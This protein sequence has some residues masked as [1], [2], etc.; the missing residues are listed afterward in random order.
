MFHRGL[1]R[2]LVLASVVILGASCRPS[3]TDSTRAA[4]T[5]LGPWSPGTSLR[6]TF[7]SFPPGGDAT[8]ALR[9]LRSNT[10]AWVERWRL[11]DGAEQ[12]IDLSYFIL[13]QDAFGIAFLGHLLERAQ[14]GV[15]I[16]LLLD[17]QGTKM[18]WTPVG[19][20]VLDE[21][22]ATGNAEVRTYRP[23]HRRVLEAFLTLTPSAAV[24]SDH[25]KIIVVDGR[26]S[27]T[28]GRNIGAEYFAERAAKP[29]AFSDADL[30]IDSVVASRVLTRAFDAEFTS[31]RAVD[32]WG[33]V[34]NVASRE[35][36]LL[37]AYRAMDAWL[38]GT[39]IESDDPPIAR[40]QDE[41]APYAALRGRLRRGTRPAALEAEARIL[42][43]QTRFDA[44][45]DPITQGLARLVQAATQSILI[46]SPYLVL[47]AD[48]VALLSAAGTRGVETT[49]LTNSPVSSDNALSQAF[50][51][52]QW[53]ELLARVPKLRLF[54]RGE[55]STLH[56]KSTVFD[57]Q[58]ATVG[59]YNLDPTSQRMNSEVIVVVWSERFAR[60]VARGPRRLIARGEP[61]VYE[62]RIRRDAAGT[63]VRGDDGRPVVE[64]GP[65]NHS[66]PSQWKTLTAFW[67]MLR[68]ADDL[69]GVSPIL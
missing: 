7:E 6:G 17:A 30:A 9:L 28:G 47:S 64:F 60:E 59:T 67:T 40:W 3:Q 55:P 57:G 16:R 36:E 43:S 12:T 5:P 39:P 29:D 18:S 61:A 1:I 34:A 20:D 15:R 26:K 42:D 25:D 49:I 38:R 56:G 13:H 63:A 69:P 58:L 10:D 19:N 8:T 23:L 54:V 14:H 2:G 66:S 51:L 45:N 11:L 37:G 46:E 22:L 53:P 65:E 27:L 62:Y 68:A 24:A 50:F 33:D 21:L 32:E 48:A 31:S 52:E 41:I 44:A 4:V 35:A